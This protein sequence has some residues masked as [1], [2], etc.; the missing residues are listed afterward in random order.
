MEADMKP[1]GIWTVL[2][3]GS[4]ILVASSAFAVVTGNDWRSLP[5]SNQTSYVMGVLDGWSIL[6][7]VG[8]T[9][10]RLSVVDCYASRG[11]TYRQNVAIVR[12][13]MDENPADWNYAMSSLVFAALKEACK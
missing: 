10:D 8:V 9:D 7:K 3:A 4:L 13:W 6:R 11:K 2:L 1:I 12:K 5:E